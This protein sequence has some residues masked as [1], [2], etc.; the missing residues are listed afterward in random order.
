MKK[1]DKGQAGFGYYARIASLIRKHGPMSVSEVASAV[2]GS[3]SSISRLMASM[4]DGVIYVS[5]WR[6]SQFKARDVPLFSLGDSP[7]VPS[8]TGRMFARKPM[9]TAPMVQFIRTI[10]A[11]AEPMT[12][13]QAMSALCKEASVINVRVQT[14][15]R[16]RLIRIC[17]Y[18]RCKLSGQP[19]PVYQLGDAPSCPK[20]KRMSK[21]EANKAHEEARQQ[22]RFERTSRKVVRVEDSVLP[23][24]SK[25][26][27]NSVF[28]WRG[29]A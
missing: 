1:N 12:K 11:F 3:A 4:C 26:A 18:E 22:R 6:K 13:R 2:G 25:L 21:S 16:N 5:E 9:Q 19:L 28:N 10:K 27:A 14:L 20:P 7:C 24:R 17:A 23:R 8:R 29:A 15:R